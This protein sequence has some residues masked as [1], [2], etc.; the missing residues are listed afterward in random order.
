VIA[1]AADFHLT[2]VKFSFAQNAN[3]LVA[4]RGPVSKSIVLTHDCEPIIK[5]QM[6]SHSA[7]S[8]LPA[9][10]KPTIGMLAD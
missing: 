8:S 3:P 5:S 7:K 9:A 2:A 1:Y 4:E 6:R 10:S